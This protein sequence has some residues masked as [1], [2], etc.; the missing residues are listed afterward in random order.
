MRHMGLRIVLMLQ[1]DVLGITSVV[2]HIKPL[3]EPLNSYAVQG[4]VGQVAG[5][6][7]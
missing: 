2:C 1:H 5:K 4:I 6:L 3:Y 7:L